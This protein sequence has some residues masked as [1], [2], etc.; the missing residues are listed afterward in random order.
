MYNTVI[1]AIEICRNSYHGRT[2]TMENE[3]T[4]E[5]IT[6]SAYDIYSRQVADELKAHLESTWWPVDENDVEGCALMETIF[7]I[8]GM[9]PP[10]YRWEFDALE[11]LNQIVAE[12]EDK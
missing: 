6:G 3:E 10:Q 4:G 8:V 9:R 11:L 1:E 7:C 2:Y 5:I 12:A